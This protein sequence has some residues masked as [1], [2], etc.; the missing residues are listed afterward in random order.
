MFRFKPLLAAGLV[1]AVL[2][3]QI[4]ISSAVAQQGQPGSRRAQ[5]CQSVISQDAVNPI[6]ARHRDRL[7]TARENM[8]REERALRTLLV[9]ETTTR[10]AVDAQIAKGNETRNAFTRARLDLL[11]DLRSVIPVQNREQAFRCAELLMR[12]R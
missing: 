8:G 7:Q 3:G 6:L 10:A 2:A 1:V 12:R 9:A 4:L 5:Q 11:W